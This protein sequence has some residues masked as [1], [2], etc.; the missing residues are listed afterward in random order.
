MATFGRGFNRLLYPSFEL[1]LLLLLVE[2]L[3]LLLLPLPPLPY[4]VR[5]R[6]IKTQNRASSTLSSSLPTNARTA[7]TKNDGAERDVAEH[8]TCSQ[9][10][11]HPDRNGQAK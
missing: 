5:K 6:N 8:S 3:L 2:L 4:T 9:V 7:H 1:I 11:I 10:I